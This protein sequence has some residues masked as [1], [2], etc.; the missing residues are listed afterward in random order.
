MQKPFSNEKKIHIFLKKEYVVWIFHTLFRIRFLI[1]DLSLVTA[2]VSHDAIS[3]QE[4]L[5]RNPRFEISRF[6]INLKLD[7]LVPKVRRVTRACCL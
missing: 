1:E 5:V 7:F 4:S 3:L 2:L 6:Q